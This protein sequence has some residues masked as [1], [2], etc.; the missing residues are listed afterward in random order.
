MNPAQ[1]LVRTA[2]LAPQAPALF[3][4]ARLEAD[5]AEFLNR[6][7]GL[8]GWVAGAIWCQQG[9]SGCGVHEQLHRISRSAL[10]DLVYRR[11]GGADK[12]QITR[13]GGRL[14]HLRCAGGA[15]LC[16]QQYWARIA[17]G[18]TCLPQKLAGCS[19]PQICPA[20]AASPASC[21]RGDW[22]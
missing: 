20:A 12:C 4:G 9:R 15:G 13:Q 3:K 18:C 16:Q 2:L 19:R 5:Y 17:R 21:A 1:W 6:V 7:A 8:A 22:R 10:C 14:D 11:C